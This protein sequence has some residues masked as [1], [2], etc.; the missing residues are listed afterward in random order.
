LLIRRQLRGPR[1]F[2]FEIGDTNDLL[3]A[4]I[5]AGAVPGPERAKLAKEIEKV[6]P[7]ADPE[8]EVTEAEPENIVPSTAP[9]WRS[10]AI[11]HM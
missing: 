11:T 6:D 9:V 4:K 8:C 2:R 5:R 10:L 7:L 1:V 3:P